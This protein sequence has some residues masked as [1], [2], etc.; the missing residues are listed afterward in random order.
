MDTRA[1]TKA[2]LILALLPAGCGKQAPP[3]LDLG[4][5]GDGDAD[6]DSDGDTDAD[7]DADAD[8]DSDADADA[9]ADADSD[10]D[11][12][13]WQPEGTCP[14]WCA[15]FVGQTT[16]SDTFNPPTAIH[17]PN[18]TC[19]SEDRVCCQPLGVD[20]G[21]DQYCNDQADHVCAESCDGPFEE[22]ATEF[23]CQHANAVCCHD[24]APTCAEMGGLCITPILEACPT[25]WEDNYDH[26]CDNFLQA[27]CLPPSCPW[28]CEPE[29]DEYSC[30]E[31]LDPPTAIHNWDYAC[32]DAPGEI[33]CQPVGAEDGIQGYC[34]DQPD[35]DC[36]TACASYETWRTDFY[37]N[38][39][40]AYCCEDTRQPC[41]DIG[42][43]CT[44]GLGCPD[45]SENNQGGT[46]SNLWELC[47]TPVDPDNTC[48][49]EG[50]TCVTWGDSCPLL[51]TPALTTSCGTWTQMC[52]QFIF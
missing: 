13:T 2:M 39:S 33:C 16:C 10:S 25:G 3:A 15:D 17:N 30:S 35:M 29:T 43:D 38:W 7:A 22:L 47:C 9:D 20:G 6:A 4:E 5:G 45:G 42:G 21:L 1:L 23:Y 18:Y 31:S 49:M 34:G 28:S 50:G 51:Y 32:L 52:C 14:W 26:D 37:C 19:D 8:A 48:A 11:S 41:A 24:F 36:K 40:T 44:T 46:C 27:C 12:D